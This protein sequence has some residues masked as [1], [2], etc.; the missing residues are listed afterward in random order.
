M[1]PIKKMCVEKGIKYHQFAAKVREANR[2]N[3]FPSREII[4]HYVAGT[5]R[6]SPKAADMI[7][8]AFPRIS[9]ESLLY[10]KKNDAA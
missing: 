4:A 10:F 1:H 6:P 7:H 2:N 5:K 3:G 9:R 8:I